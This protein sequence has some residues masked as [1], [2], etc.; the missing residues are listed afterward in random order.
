MVTFCAGQG[1]IIR[2]GSSAM[3]ILHLVLCSLCIVSCARASTS[4]ETLFHQGRE[5][6]YLLH[7]ASSY[8][9]KYVVPL[10]FVFHGGGGNAKQI[11]RFTGFNDLSDQHKFL[12][13]YPQGIDGHWN[14]GR[15][16][17]AF[18]EQDLQINDIDFILKLLDHLKQQ[19][20]IDEKRV[21]ATG[22]SN[23]G[24]FC[25]RLAIEQSAHFA[26]VATVIGSIAE[27]LAK[28]FHPEKAISVMIMNGTDDPLVPYDGGEVLPGLGKMFRTAQRGSVLSTERALEL[29]IKHNRITVQPDVEPLPNINQDDG[30]TVE[31]TEWSNNDVSV[32]LYKIIGGGHTYPGGAQY[33][34][35]RI[36]GATC[37]DIEA[38]EII[39]N[40]FANHT[41]R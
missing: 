21:F 19:Y 3:R 14:D 29:W 30:A 39:W 35:E 37:R 4:E 11:A 16:A 23:G 1:S 28:N 18:R 41:R 33:L 36:I 27:P 17:Q 15:N 34:P 20:S 32:V 5:R 13:V 26:A 7:I 6:Q 22:L 9:S 31:R 38:S 40:F 10:V 24:I 2:D 12:V 25:Q 8:D